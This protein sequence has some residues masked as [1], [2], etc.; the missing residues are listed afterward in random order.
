MVPVLLLGAGKIGGAIAR[1][2]AGCGDYDVCVGDVSDNALARLPQSMPNLATVRMDVSN[3]A[4]LRSAMKDRRIVVSA[5][6]FD[7]NVGIAQAALDSGLSYFDLTEDVET[8]VAIQKIAKSARPGQV[9][10][11]QCGLAP[12]FVSIAACTSRA[13]LTSSTRSACASARCRSSRRTR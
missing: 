4:A 10:A 12:G 2:L 7:V 13:T 1:L 5:C 6:S 11:P 3:A 8:T 9:F